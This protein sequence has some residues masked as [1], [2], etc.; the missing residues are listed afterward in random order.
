MVAEDA[1]SFF[2]TSLR[3][4]EVNI[5]GWDLPGL[6]ISLTFVAMQRSLRLS[7]LVSLLAQSGRL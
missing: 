7:R 1:D 4:R 2:F 6:F 3:R 5:Y